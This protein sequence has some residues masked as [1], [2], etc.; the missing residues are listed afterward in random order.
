MMLEQVMPHPSRPELYINEVITPHNEVKE[1]DK[2]EVNRILLEEVAKRRSV[3]M[4][5]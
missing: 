2:M 4:V 1:S 5:H 3:K